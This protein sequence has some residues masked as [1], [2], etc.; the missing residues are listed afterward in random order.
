MGDIIVASLKQLLIQLPALLVYLAVM[1]LAVVFWRRCPAA[2]MLVLPAAG[3]LL[4]S[5][6]V[7][8]FAVQYIARS[9][10]RW[11]WSHTR[12]SVVWSV[13]GLVNSFVHAV[14]LSLIVSAA[15]VARRAQPAGR[16]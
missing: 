12:L 2:T 10:G 3:L 14:G 1:I 4:L 6:V 15:F 8:T 5:L 13:A 16:P 11:G 9:F 7:W